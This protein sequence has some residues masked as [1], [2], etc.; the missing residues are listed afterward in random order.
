[1]L[2]D[3]RGSV[4]AFHAKSLQKKAQYAAC[5]AAVL[6][7]GLVASGPWLTSRPAGS[8]WH[9]LGLVVYGFGQVV[10]H[11]RVDRSFLLGGVP[12]PV[13][14]RCTG[15]YAGAVVRGASHPDAAKKWIDAHPDQVQAWL[16]A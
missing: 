11:Q 15:I 10:C 16:K 7:A 4:V 5:A 2:D 14:A 6:W 13:C 12:L 3:R 9:P 8:A 1:M